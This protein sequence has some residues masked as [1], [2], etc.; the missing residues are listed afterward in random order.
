MF[1]FLFCSLN[2]PAQTVFS[3]KFRSAGKGPFLASK[4]KK[5]HQR[6]TF[7]V[8]GQAGHGLPSFG[9]SGAY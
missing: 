2:I 1:F 5:I 3:L 8:G 9:N 6:C 4:A 7:L